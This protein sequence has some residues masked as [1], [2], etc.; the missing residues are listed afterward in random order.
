AVVGPLIDTLAARPLWA[1]PFLEQASRE[2]PDPEGLTRL[3]VGLARRH[4]PLSATTVAQASARIADRGRYDLAWQVHRTGHPNAVRG[5]VQD[6]NFLA[7]GEAATPFGWS[8][9]GSNGVTAELR[10]YGA[11]NRLAYMAAT[12][13]GGPAARQLLL[14]PTG[15]FTL[16][17]QASAIAA[18][19]PGPRLRLTCAGS[20]QI[21]AQ[22]PTTAIRAGDASLVGR[23]SIPSRCPAQWLE[24]VIDGGDSPAG[25][26]GEIGPVR[27]VPVGG[28]G[29]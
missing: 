20:G 23:F 28:T 25:A 3:I 19:S 26:S 24:V 18:D 15:S 10:S 22:V 21:I 12:G 2:A 29:K 17:A 14:L 16:D 9:L 6:P 8:I 4:Y 13:A 27:V 11:G 7:A 5:Q 1:D